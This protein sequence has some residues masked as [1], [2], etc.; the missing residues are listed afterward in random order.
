MS[1]EPTV[2]VMTKAP[3]PGT[4]KTRLHPL[5]GPNGCARLQTVMLAH[6]IDVARS[7][8][9]RVVVAFDPPDAAREIGGLVGEDVELVRQR[10]AHLGERMTLAADEALPAGGPL[11]VIGTDAPT[12]TATLIDDAFT[13]LAHGATAVLGPALDGGYY[14]LATHWPYPAAFAIDPQL[15]GG[16]QVLLATVE[17]LRQ[18]GRVELLSALRDLDTPEDAAALLTEPGL[19]PSIANALTGAEAEAPV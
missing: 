8:G 2:L 9:R 18:R 1:G 14:L 11:V 17:R 4:V 5:L 19:P 3:R 10:G 6:T 15:W 12:L 16:P 7:A 13:Q